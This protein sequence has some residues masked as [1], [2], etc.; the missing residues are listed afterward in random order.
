M[1]VTCNAPKTSVT[2]SLQVIAC[3]KYGYNW[4]SDVVIVSVQEKCETYTEERQATKTSM[5]SRYGYVE[6]YILLYS[7]FK[8]RQ[9]VKLISSI[10]LSII[11]SACPGREWNPGRWR[12]R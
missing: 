3:A 1:A 10:S 7:L 2:Y 4:S 8:T 12:Q 9:Q 6:R 11:E 5:A